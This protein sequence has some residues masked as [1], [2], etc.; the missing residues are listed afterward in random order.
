MNSFFP[1]PQEIEAAIAT[2]RE[3][4]GQDYVS[5]TAELTSY[6]P[7]EDHLEVLIWHSAVGK[8]FTGNSLESAMASV[9]G[10]S[11]ADHINEAILE[12]E[13]ELAELRKNLE[14]A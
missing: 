3:K 12:K 4:L 14:A 1:T 9:M 2:L 11:K 7:G 5:I 8:F 6:R 10:R 13:A